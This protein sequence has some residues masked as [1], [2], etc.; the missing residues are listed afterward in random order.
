MP[1]EFTKTTPTTW[2]TVW[3]TPTNAVFNNYN[4]VYPN[5]GSPGKPL[6]NSAPLKKTEPEDPPLWEQI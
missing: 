4:V 1:V 2:T 5:N 6:Y 3:T